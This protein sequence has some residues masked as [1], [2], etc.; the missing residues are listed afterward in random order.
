MTAFA[1]WWAKFTATKGGALVERVLVAA[2]STA[3]S[4]F[5]GLLVTSSAG[6]ISVS[7]I[8]AAITAAI[9]AGV[10]ALQSILTMAFSKPSAPQLL[11][12]HRE[13]YTARRTELG[14]AA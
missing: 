13:A 11:R 12:R 14:I 7:S 10:A 1:A 8:H 9:T 3:L 6:P 4:T 2:G 5:V